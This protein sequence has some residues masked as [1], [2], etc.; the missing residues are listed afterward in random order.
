M[1]VSVSTGALP[2][3]AGETHRRG[4]VLAVLL[5]VTALL[6]LASAGSHWYAY[7]LQVASPGSPA[8]P[9]LALLDVNSES[10]VP[11]WWSTALLLAGA[12]LAAVCAS[13]APAGPVRRGWGSLA[14]LFAAVSLDEAAALHERFL[15]PLGEALLGGADA[16][17]LLHF[18]WL[19]PGVAVLVIAAAAAV[20]LLAPLPRVTRRALLVAVSVWVAGAFLLEAASGVVFRAVGGTEPYVLVTLLEEG[21]EMTGVALAVR[22]VLR[23]LAVRREPGLVALTLQA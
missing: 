20:R 3:A 1:S 22:A 4:P 23:A 7:R 15:D 11:T 8:H 21:A 14:G 19:A 10:N 12:A 9:L 5:G 16:G 18:A 17:G 2:G 6:L 13:V